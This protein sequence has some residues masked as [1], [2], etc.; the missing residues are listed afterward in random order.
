VWREAGHRLDREDSIVR[1]EVADLNRVLTR[2]AADSALYAQVLVRAGHPADW[3]ALVAS[4][5][6]VTD[7][8][9]PTRLAE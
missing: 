1:F 3:D 9:P 5:F 7:E 8:W 2:S 4:C 6:A